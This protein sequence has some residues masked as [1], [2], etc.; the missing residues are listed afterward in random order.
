MPAYQLRRQCRGSMNTIRISLGVFGLCCLAAA[1]ARA[2]ET[3]H[4]GPGDHVEVKV[5]DFRAG[6]GEAYQWTAFSGSPSDF[7]VGP[8]G[9]LSLPTVGQIDA[10][11][12]TTAELEV[13]IATR[14]QAKAGLT[15]RPDVSVQI[16]KFR[17]FY[18]I[19]IVDK[20]G[21][22]DYRPGLTVLQAVGVGGGLEHSASDTMLGYLKDSLIARGDLRVLAAD[23]E[24]LRAEQARLDAEIGNRDAIVYPDD[25]RDKSSNPDTARAMREE[26]LLFE[27]RRGGIANQ[28]QIIEKNKAYLHDEISSL[29]QKGITVVTQLT[30][31]RKELDMVS[32]LV[33]KGLTAVPRELELEQNIAQIQGNQLDIQ[34]AEVRANED[35]AKSDRDILDLQ[36]TRRNEELTEAA[37]VRVKLSETLEKIQTSQALIQQAEVRAPMETMAA[38]DGIAK[39]AYLLSRHNEKGEPETIPA[40]ESDLVQPGDVVRVMLRL[41]DTPPRSSDAP[42]APPR[43][44]N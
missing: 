42:L 30:A 14:L 36:T 23:L 10:V 12:N 7:I 28:I 2:T 33:A 21:E 3:Y 43:G 13:T 39:P 4:L 22:Y 11:G 6:T 8:D 9:R 35:I 18:V 5:S 27:S 1:P 38:L 26:Q 25:L 44:V 19:G 29:G 24:S 34:L 20:P 40:Q 37:E 17:P 16:V 32:T 31:M 15:T 41:P